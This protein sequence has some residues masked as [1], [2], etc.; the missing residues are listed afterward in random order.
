MKLQEITDV[1]EESQL[2][3]ERITELESLIAEAEQLRRKQFFISSASLL[4][5]LIILTA[6]IIGLA[7]YFKNYPKRTLMLEVLRNSRYALSNPYLLEMRH[8]LDRKIVPLFADEFK[9]NLQ[10]ELSLLKQEIR[11][12]ARS[13]VHY[14][15]HNLRQNFRTRIRTLLEENTQDRLEKG[16]LTPDKNQESLLKQMNDKL[17]DRITDSVFSVIMPT[18]EKL[19]ALHEELEFLRNSRDYMDLSTEPRDFIES[20]LIEDTLETIIYSLNES[21]GLV[22]ANR[23]VLP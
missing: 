1:E 13:T 19:Y 5:M 14:A 9:K 11:M 15:Q 18:P 2:V 8:G 21:K 12:E 4:L 7:S 20:R 16:N 3:G 10:K 23:G 6:F 22:P 17:A